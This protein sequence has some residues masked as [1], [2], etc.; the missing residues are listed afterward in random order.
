MQEEERGVVKVEA[1]PPQKKKKIRFR[2]RLGKQTKKHS[3]NP[4]IFI[5]SIFLFVFKEKERDGKK[6]DGTV[7]CNEAEPWNQRAVRSKFLGRQR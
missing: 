5:E 1:P 2:P 7:R 3:G 6:K 4:V